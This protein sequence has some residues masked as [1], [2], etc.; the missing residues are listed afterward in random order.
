MKINLSTRVSQPF[1]KVK[2]GFTEDLF[3][4]LNPPFPPVKLLRFDGSSTGDIVSLE[5]NFIF[6]KQVW[7][8]E[9]TEDQTDE[10]EF[11]FVDEGKE[12]PFFLRSWRHKHRVVRQGVSQSLIIDEINYRAPNRLLG[13]LLFPVL[14]AQF[15][16]RKPV[17]KKYFRHDSPI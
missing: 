13:L 5:L 11:Y 6:F 9:I 10:K 8:S 4:S 7:T 12:L 1:L 3:E 17:Y 15:A 16:M 14:Y 2:E